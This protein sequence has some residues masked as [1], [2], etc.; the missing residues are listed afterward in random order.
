VQRN[1]KKKK[2]AGKLAEYKVNGEEG[3]GQKAEQ[4]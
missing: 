1:N 4:I 3:R 2:L